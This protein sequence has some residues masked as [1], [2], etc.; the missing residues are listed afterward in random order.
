MII[1]PN[2]NTK[3]TTINKQIKRTDRSHIAQLAGRAINAPR[4]RFRAADAVLRAE[5]GQHSH[6]FGAAILC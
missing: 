1:I 6:R 4:G 2:N 3:S 5:F